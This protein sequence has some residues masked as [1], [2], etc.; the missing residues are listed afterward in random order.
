M[1]EVQKSRCGPSVK[2][3]SAVTAVSVVL[4]LS[5]CE[6]PTGL[7]MSATDWALHIPVG[8][9]SFQGENSGFSLSRLTA[10]EL[11]AALDPDGEHGIVVYD[12]K[13]APGVTGGGYLWVKPG[14]DA[15]KGTEQQTYLIH[16]PVPM[17]EREIKQKMKQNFNDALDVLFDTAFGAK[18]DNGFIEQLPVEG[19]YEFEIPLKIDTAMPEEAF[20]ITAITNLDYDVRCT[21]KENALPRINGTGNVINET[22]KNS[23]IS[24][25]RFKKP[26]NDYENASEVV[27]DLEN[28]AVVWRS[29]KITLT[30]LGN[31]EVELLTVN[32]KLLPEKTMQLSGIKYQPE[33]EVHDYDSI[34]VTFT[35]DKDGDMGDT[36][37]FSDLMAMLGGAQFSQAWCYIFSE[38][39]ISN[40]TVKAIS[41]NDTTDIINSNLAANTGFKHTSF[42]G[43]SLQNPDHSSKTDLTTTILKKNAPVYTLQ[44]HIPDTTNATLKNGAGVDIALVVPLK[45]SVTAGIGDGDAK[46]VTAANETYLK[47]HCPQL[48]DILG[49]GNDFDL[50][51]EIN[52]QDIGTL[53]SV[54]ATLNVFNQVLPEELKIGIAKNRPKTTT[55]YDEVLSLENGETSSVEYANTNE[56]IS[57][58]RPALLLGPSGAAIQCFSIAPVD[59]TK[60]EAEREVAVR[61]IADATIDFDYKVKF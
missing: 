16:Y 15:I 44:Y 9:T 22:N 21:F 47:L 8:T 25:V 13:K 57:M 35:E 58:P 43:T 36:A 2:K 23:F 50:R 55:I 60:T 19:G 20:K 14:T 30:G 6:A 12:G 48:D 61:I 26:D 59:D 33:L 28:N 11:Q 37:A 10:P 53:K 52:K 46:T 41:Q 45:F 49:A 7:H 4:A 29:P 56:P 40:L 32:L 39:A 51:E 3:I 34:N 27:L 24:W 18:T 31:S 38:V 5:A 54:K 1:T 17:G 42:Y